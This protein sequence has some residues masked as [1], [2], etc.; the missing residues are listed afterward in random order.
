MH[1][2]H[3]ASPRLSRDDGNESNSRNIV[4]SYSAMENSQ[5]VISPK[6]ALIQGSK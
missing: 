4:P 5:K 3:K 2:T 6:K 1:T